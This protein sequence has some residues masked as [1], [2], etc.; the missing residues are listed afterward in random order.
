RI[1]EGYGATEAG[2]VLSVNTPMHHKKR[3]VGRFLPGISHHLEPVQGIDDGGRLWVHGPNVM[4]G[5]LF[6]STPGKLNPP[7]DNWYD[8]G[9][10]AKIDEEGYVHLLGRAKRFAKVGGEM[11]SLI[12]VEEAVSRLWPEF[13]HGVIAVPHPR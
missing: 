3:T 8:T 10:I 11:I 7:K 2:P 4:L 12:S 9:D 5:Y 13:I 6:A 1:F